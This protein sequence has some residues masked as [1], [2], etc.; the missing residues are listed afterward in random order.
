[1][2]HKDFFGNAVDIINE[3]TAPHSDHRSTNDYVSGVS[4]ICMSPHSDTKFVPWAVRA[5]V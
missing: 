3:Q 4:G 5:N 2:R 1:M